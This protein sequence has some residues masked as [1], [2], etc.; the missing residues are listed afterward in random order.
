MNWVKKIWDRS[1]TDWRYRGL[2]HV[3]FWWFLLFFWTQESI[4]IKINWQQHYSVTM[5]GAALA[6]FLYYPL[7]YLI[8]PLIKK[9]KWIASSILFIIY[10]VVA[11]ILRDYHINMMIN[12]Y[13]LKQAWVVGHDFWP[14]VYKNQ[15]N[16]FGLTRVIFSSIPS[17]IQIIYIPLAVKFI[18]YAYQFNQK[19]AWLAKQNTELQLSTLRAQL[20][21][22]FFFNTLN[23][24]Q[25]FIVQNDKNRSVELLNRLADFMRTSLYDCEEKY[26]SMEKEIALLNNYIFIERV[27]F[28][29]KAEININL[30]DLDPAYNLPPFI[31]M[32]FIENAFKHGGAQL[33]EDTFI[34]ISLVNDA[35]QIILK[36]KN[37]YGAKSSPDGIGIKNVCARLEHFYPKKHNLSVVKNERFYEVTLEIC[38]F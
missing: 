37:T 17:L 20:N 35:K 38:K 23:N 7:I 8:L 11:V 22:H 24:L 6:L 15:F 9:K 33:P 27:R 28:D 31:F 19:Q 18:R 1:F 13:N 21:P 26:I 12:W 5:V 30:T 3:A 2:L 25:S 29:E 14:Q 4:V 36:T 16:P 10:Y 34:D 32:P